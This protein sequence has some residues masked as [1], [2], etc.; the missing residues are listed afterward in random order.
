MCVFV[1]RGLCESAV[2]LPL[3]VMHYSGEVVGC[4]AGKFAPLVA[5]WGA[6]ARLVLGVLWRCQCGGLRLVGDGLA[7]QSLAQETLLLGSYVS[8]STKRAAVES[9]VL[10]AGLRVYKTRLQGAPEAAG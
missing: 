1:G 4:G 3:C 6:E 9:L 10:S 8:Q 7:V 5:R 2:V